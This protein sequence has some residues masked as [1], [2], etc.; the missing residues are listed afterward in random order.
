MKTTKPGFHQSHIGF[1]E[2][3]SDRKICIVTASTHSLEIIKDLAGGEK[4]YLEKQE[5]IL[6][7]IPHTQQ[8]QSPQG[9]QKLRDCYWKETSTFRCFCDKPIYKRFGDLVI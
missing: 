6:K 3:P 2:Y 8:D 5:L 9:G 7:S 1:S 4:S